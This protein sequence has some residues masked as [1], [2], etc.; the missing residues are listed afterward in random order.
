TDPF[1]GA[2]IACNGALLTGFGGGSIPPGGKGKIRSQMES[3]AQ[4]RPIR[5]GRSETR[6]SSRCPFCVDETKKQGSFDEPPP[7]EG[8]LPLA[9]LEAWVY[10]RGTTGHLLLVKRET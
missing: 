4:R 2:V 10:C 3:V 6:Y 5:V 8:E 9:D 1:K 7:L